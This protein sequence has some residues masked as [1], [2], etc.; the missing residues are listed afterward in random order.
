VDYSPELLPKPSS[1][2]G[3][4][5][6]SL[7]R[8]LIDF[9]AVEAAPLPPP[10]ESPAI[11]AENNP[12]KRRKKKPS[13]PRPSKGIPI[14]FTF[15]EAVQLFR[16]KTNM[17]LE[18]LGQ[19]T[20]GLDPIL[21]RRIEV[22]SFDPPRPTRAR[23][24]CAFDRTQQELLE[25]ANEFPPPA[26]AALGQFVRTLRDRQKIGF[27]DFTAK[28][29]LRHELDL[30]DLENGN[31]DPAPLETYRKIARA[32]RITLYELFSLKLPVDRF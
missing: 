11:T 9:A 23:I 28:I 1:S 8:T 29:N 2:N 5:G 27:R 14:K 30:F 10:P 19:R 15:G 20:N 7:A 31:A 12:P 13:V 25:E 16:D 32:L 3:T 21:L 18:E 24:A 22:G 4:R 26:A 6:F 17:T